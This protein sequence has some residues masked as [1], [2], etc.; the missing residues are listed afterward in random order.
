[1]PGHPCLGSVQPD[2]VV[3]AVEQ[4]VP[5]PSPEARS[6]VERSAS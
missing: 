2:E 4:L 5:T 6:L 1:V 3:A